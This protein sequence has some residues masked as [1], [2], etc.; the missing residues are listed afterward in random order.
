MTCLTIPTLTEK[1]N[2]NFNKKVEITD[3]CH[4]WT[5][6]TTRTKKGYGEFWIN[7]RLYR[8]HRVSYFIANGTIDNELEIDHKCEN[9]SCVNPAHLEQVTTQENLRRRTER[10]AVRKATQTV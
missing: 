2:E 4:I 1:Q 3:D 9:T 8:A 10:R 7:D 5:A 6:T